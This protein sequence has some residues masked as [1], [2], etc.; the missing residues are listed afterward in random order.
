MTIV[1]K[2]YYKI[3]YFHAMCSHACLLIANTSVRACAFALD[4]V[5]V[6]ICACISVCASLHVS[7]SL[8]VS[9]CVH[10]MW[11][12]LYVCA[13]NVH[14]DESIYA[15]L[16]LYANLCVYMCSIGALSES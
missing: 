10:M 16:Y 12:Q 13:Y 1:F 9:L 6:S 4:G 11:V 15:F 7:V 8:A 3:A 14:A 5:C 2:G